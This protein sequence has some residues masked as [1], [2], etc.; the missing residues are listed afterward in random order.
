M[1]TFYS[2]FYSVTYTVEYTVKRVKNGGAP[3]FEVVSNLYPIARA[4]AAPRRAKIVVAVPPVIAEG[5]QTTLWAGPD[6]PMCRAI[7]YKLGPLKLEGGHG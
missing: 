1:N 2:A 6:R 5:R 3:Y 4:K 7:G